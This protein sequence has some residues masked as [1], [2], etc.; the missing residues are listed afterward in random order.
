MMKRFMLSVLSSFALV[1]SLS[2]QVLAASSVAPSELQLV[3]E[4][5]ISPELQAVLE[6]VDFE[7]LDRR[8]AE[9]GLEE[10][11]P[12]V[13]KLNAQG[14]VVDLGVLDVKVALGDGA[15]AFIGSANVIAGL[16][17]LAVGASTVN[18]LLV[19]AGVYMVGSGIVVAY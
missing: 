13:V 3:E 2:S 14:E 15:A 7:E 11:D 8:A 16:V 19:I 18:G 12:V 9:L 17:M 6:R 10:G 4:V 5:E 1:F